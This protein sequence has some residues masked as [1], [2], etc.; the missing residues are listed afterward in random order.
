MTRRDE[1][2]DRQE[3]ARIREGAMARLR[4]PLRL[5]RAALFAERL[6]RG[7]WPFSTLLLAAAAA[8]A[9]GLQ[10]VLPLE[11]LWV[12]LVAVVLGL[13]ATLVTGLRRFRWP[14]RAEAAARLDS[15]LPGRP[16]AAL[17]ETQ[18]LGREDSAASA[19]WRIHLQRMAARAAAARAR[20]PDLRLASRDRYG[21]RYAALMLF[22]LAVIFGAPSRVAEVAEIAAGGNPASAA[23][24]P[25]WEGWVEPPAYTGRPSL[26]LNALEVERLELP[27]GSRFTFRFYGTPG[28]IR[29][30]QDVAD[31]APPPPE[32][33]DAAG[34]STAAAP[35][36]SAEFAA[37]RSGTVTVE[38]AGGRAFEVVVLPDR[39][40]AVAFSG[41]IRREADGQMGQPFTATDDFQ[42]V[43]GRAEITLDL[44]AV[45]RRFGLAAEPEP[46]DPYVL[47]L[48]LPIT[49]DR[50]SFEETLIDN[51]SKHPFANLPV[52]MVLTVEDGLGQTGQ[53]E[54]R[55]LI[56]PGR[57]FFDPLAAAIIEMR[58]DLLWSGD[59]AGRSLQVL[60]AIRNRPEGFFRNPRSYL[61]LSVAMRRMEAGLVDGRMPSELRDEMA[62]ELWEIAVLIEDGGLSDALARMQRAQE[63]LSEAIRNGASPEEIQALM[64]EL[65][66]ATD[67][68][69]R[70]LAE[71]GEQM[72]EEQMA[73]GQGQQ[74]TGDQIQQMMDEIQ[75]LMEEGRM[76]EAQELL[77]QFNRMME[78]MRVT[79]G[80]G[81]EGDMPGGQAMQDLAD[82]L[83]EQQGLSDETFREGQEGQGQQGQPGQGQPGQG[84]PGQGQ[85]GQG[86]PGQGQPGQGQPG[87][88]QPGQGGG[89]LADRQ[90]ALRNELGRQQGNLP[91]AG[92]EAGDAARDALGR[93]GRAMDQAEQALR[94][95][96]TGTAIDR[97][98]EAIEQLREGLRNL[99]EEMA[100][101]NGQQGQQPGGQPGEG[102][103]RQAQNGQG[104]QRDPLGRVLGQGGRAGSDENLL[105]GEDVYRRARD[106]LD[107][108][109][110][111]AGE[112][113][114]PDLELDY[115]RRLL[116]R[117]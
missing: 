21:L 104:G 41:A 58:R 29:V 115:L 53:S 103:Q 12:T 18:A 3:D 87:Q 10:D 106:L 7:F 24:G 101:Q 60:R 92:S 14:S 46:R 39:G 93:A 75:R 80:Q 73:Q 47:D 34:T 113:E 112:Q 77:E 114:R 66:Q 78:N 4:V 61:M 11:V 15:G 28:S 26:Y 100:R 116:D 17:A 70:Q 45:D 72:P 57:R 108:I 8:F 9:F 42:I 54:E 40:P 102:D 109:R 76:A 36:Q 49:G 50:A 117:F 90:Q 33:G 37:A 74:I 97:Q 79:Q 25:S 85:P 71:R 105:Q 67:D 44:A 110:R 30:E 111:R 20:A 48:P 19:V 62:E 55:S 13:V 63:R 43:A 86:Q 68:Y 98:A 82:T 23:A 31:A 56:L 52:K 5:T 65:R 32:Q 69:I 89:S 51:A 1:R 94:D 91:G 81:G 22:V 2:E 6:A 83:R 95:G 16:L 27:E 35:P 96:D 38:G 59:N 88:G 64:D 84:Q 99:G 107:E